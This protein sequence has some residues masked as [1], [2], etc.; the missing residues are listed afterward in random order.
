MGKE[1]TLQRPYPACLIYTRTLF[2]IHLCSIQII[3][4][5]AL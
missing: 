3:D 1:Y 2:L 5:G 4:L